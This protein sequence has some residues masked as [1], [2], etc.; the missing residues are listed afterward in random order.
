M[1]KHRLTSYLLGG[2]STKRTNMEVGPRRLLGGVVRS[3]SSLDEHAGRRR[4]AP[5]KIVLHDDLPWLRLG[6]AYFLMAAVCSLP[7][8]GRGL[9]INTHLRLRPDISTAF[10]MAT[11]LPS[12]AAPI[13]GRLTDLLPP[14]RRKIAAAALVVEAANTGGNSS[15][16]LALRVHAGGG[17]P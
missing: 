2:L 3:E 10:Y 17:I 14:S 9:I 11:W 6:G 8:V 15:V 4:A 13:V 7:M 12:P 5:F 16:I 1:N